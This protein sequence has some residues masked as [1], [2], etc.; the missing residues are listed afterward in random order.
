[1]A[2]QLS[3]SLRYVA[4]CTLESFNVW[5]DK[6][7]GQA[8]DILGPSSTKR[9]RI[10]A[11]MKEYL[12][13]TRVGEDREITVRKKDKDLL[14]K[15][16]TETMRWQLS[17][18]WLSLPCPTTFSSTFDAGRVGRPAKELLLHLG[19]LPRLRRGIPLPP[20]APR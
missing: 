20:R 1:M 19:Y 15:V 2:A 11:H 8:N 3:L 5:G 17:S 10:S 9:R 7:I 14:P 16:K 18:N 6:D 13:G 12:A 4:H